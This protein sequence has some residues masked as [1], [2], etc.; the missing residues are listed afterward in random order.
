[1]TDWLVLRLLLHGA[2]MHACRADRRARHPSTT[3]TATPSRPSVHPFK[4]KKNTHVLEALEGDARG[5]GDDEVVARHARRELAEGLR[6]DVG[7][8]RHDDHLRVLLFFFV[9]LG[10]VWEGGGV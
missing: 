8:H 6:D 1:M 2:C 7:L 10:C 4:R 9:L 5:D 3:T